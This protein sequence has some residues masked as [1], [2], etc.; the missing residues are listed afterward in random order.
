MLNI[1]KS[2]DAETLAPTQTATYTITVSHDPTSTASA[3]DIVIGDLLDPQITLVPGSVTVTGPDGLSIDLGNGAFDSALSISLAELALGETITITYQAT[4]NVSGINPL[5][6]V[7]NT[8]SLDYDSAPGPGGRLDASSDEATFDITASRFNRT[9][10]IDGESET[11]RRFGVADDNNYVEDELHIDPIYTGAV[12]PNATV[13]LTLVNKSG[14]V[15]GKQTV[16]ADAGGNWSINLPLSEVQSRANELVSNRYFDQTQLFDRPTGLFG[17][18]QSLLGFADSNR[19]A[20]VGADVSGELLTVQVSSDRPT[21][22]NDPSDQSNLRTY[23]TPATRGS[24]V[25][26]ANPNEDI[27][28]VFEERAETAVKRL[29]DGA[30]SPTSFGANKFNEEFL[31]NSGVSGK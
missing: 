13:N 26:G 21:F 28:D 4:V 29:S 15:I 12:T 5:I 23:F 25:Y 17:G 11:L 24:E 27:E 2:V 1:E 20:S 31:A 6:P 8:A 18:D 16:V 22:V 30:R 19:G 9:Q 7:V 10:L 3:A 14:A